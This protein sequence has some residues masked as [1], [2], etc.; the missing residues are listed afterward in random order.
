MGILIAAGDSLDIV[1]YEWKSFPYGMS[2]NLYESLD[3]LIDLESPLW[4]GMADIV[5][6]FAYGGK[7]YCYPYRI[8]TNY[9]LNYNR[10]AL[11]EYS[12]PD[13]YDLYMES[14]WTWDTFKQLLVDWCNV[15]NEH[16]GYAVEGGMSFIATTGAQLISVNDDGTISNNINDPN[17]TRAMV[18]CSS[19]Y[20]NG[21]MYQDEF[22]EWV[23]P[24]LW[25]RNSRRLLFLGMNPEW[26]Y[27]AATLELQNKQGI[28][29]D[30]FDT[31]S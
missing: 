11:K 23:S 22:N 5:D 29:N 12:L 4:S 1:S 8:A 25:A 13:P 26:T 27:T 20:R 19:L 3:G 17:V 28:D 6:S 16:I 2:K 24:Q 21:L 14:S 10:E 30:I 31:V 7:R 15:D 9:A 18:F